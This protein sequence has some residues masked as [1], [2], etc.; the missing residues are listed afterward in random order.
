MPVGG[1]G[2][3]GR[4]PFRIGG[5]LDWRAASACLLI[6]LVALVVLTHR[7]YGVTWDEEAQSRYGR[8]ILRWYDSGFT[9]EGAFGHGN[10]VYYGGL[11]EVLAELA[12]TQTP[13]SGYETRHLVN[14]LVGLLAI[15]AT[16]RLAAHL[17][18]PLAGF[19]AAALVVLTPAFYG[20]LF[21]N[22]KDVPFAA[23]HSLALWAI[24]STWDSMPKP[25]PSRLLL[26]GVAIGAASAVRAGGV[27]L[28]FHLGTLWA[29]WFLLRRRQRDSLARQAA[30][31]AGSAALVATA[32]WCVMLAFWPWATRSPFSAPF[33]ALRSTAWL[34]PEGQTLFAGRLVR[35]G[36]LPSG[37]VLVWFGVSLPE[38]YLAAAVAGAVGVVRMLRGGLPSDALRSDAAVKLAWLASTC[39]MPVAGS[40]VLKA[41]LYDG[42]RHFLFAIPV[43]AVLASVALASYLRSEPWRFA[44]MAAAAVLGALAATTTR[45]MVRL[46]PY[47]HIYFNRLA[48]GVGAASRRFET[49]Y[50]LSSYKEGIAWL[51]QR[52][53]AGYERRVRVACTFVD[54]PC[55][56]YLKGSSEGRGRFVLVPIDR[57]PHVILASTRRRFHSRYRG[58]VLHVVE[59]EGAE[60]LHVIEVRRPLAVFLRPPRPDDSRRVAPP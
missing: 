12:A 56:Y 42:I 51:V 53:G 44:R 35:S 5:L 23:F 29:A 14:G 18:G 24:L 9:H 60:L 16:E 55:A 20:H 37:Y 49:D 27:L 52:Y 54:F 47:Q 48:G 32:A 3:A 11:F 59:R 26:S 33:T 4:S 36:D 10:L 39:A 19:L 41:S 15:L 43:M 28:L 46:H 25:R 38:L 13:D 57:D 40:V 50:W 22:P 58:R 45:D 17:C 31:L 1:D 21:N 6:V 34:N 2:C 8:R 7:D 30:L